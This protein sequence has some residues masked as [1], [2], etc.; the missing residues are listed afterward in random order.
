[1]IISFKLRDLLKKQAKTICLNIGVFYTIIG[2]FS[3]VMLKMQKTMITSFDTPDD[4]FL[5]LMNVLHEIWSIYMPIMVFLGI[6][7][8]LFGL[9]FTKIEA[10]KYKISLILRVLSIVWVIA[11]SISSIEFIK[12]FFESFG[13]GLE[14]FK[15]VAIPFAIFGFVAVAAIFTVPQYVIGKKILNQETV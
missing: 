3:F 12:V 6:C 2:V 10:N 4:N 7:Y 1:M 11:Y 9:F 5:Q 14:M 13:N 15:Y 8:I